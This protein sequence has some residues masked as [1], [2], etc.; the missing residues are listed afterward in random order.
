MIAVFDR[1]EVRYWTFREI[2]RLAGEQGFSVTELMGVAGKNLPEQID[3]M[4]AGIRGT[5]Q[6]G[7]VIN[8]ETT[9]VLYRVKVK[10]PDY[11]RLLKLMVNC[12]YNATVETLRA[13]SSFPTWPEFQAYLQAQGTDKVPEEVLSVYREHHARYAAFREICRQIR[14]WASRRATEVLA[15]I[16]DGDARTRRAAFARAIQTDPLKPLLFSAFDGRLTL[17]KAEALFD[18]PEEANQALAGLN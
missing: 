10:S 16:P 2:I 6:E 7:S 18:T 11:L 8:F 12:T 13:C 5:D 17:A 9:E 15:T 3:H 4:L 14:D 1:R